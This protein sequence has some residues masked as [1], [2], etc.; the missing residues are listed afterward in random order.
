MKRPI[1][2]DKGATLVSNTGIGG[3]LTTYTVIAQ[4]GT[5]ARIT[6]DPPVRAVAISI[7]AGADVAALDEGLVY[8]F[9]AP[10]TIVA[11]DWLTETINGVPRHKIKQADGIRTHYFDGAAISYI[12]I[13]AVGTAVDMDVT[14][15]GV[16]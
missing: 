3:T 7:L 13:K 5:P 16:V 14:I 4:A 9:S 2:D 10:T 6:F 12:D 8:C 15:E 11:A 1:Y